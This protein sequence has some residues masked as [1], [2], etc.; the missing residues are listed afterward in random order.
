MKKRKELD[1]LIG[2]GG[3]SKRK[4]TKKGSGHRLLR[5]EPPD[6][7]SVSSSDEDE[8][9]TL[10]SSGFKG[11]YTQC[12]KVCY[13]LCAF[14]VLVACVVACCGL[15]WMQVALKEDLDAMKEKIRTMES[16]Q[17]ISSHEI[18]KL[19]EDLLEKQKLLEN[20]ESGSKGLNK[21]WTNMTE[22]NKQITLLDSTVSHLKANIK[23]ASDL[24]NLPTTV[25]ELQKSVASIGS[26][27]T[28]VQHDVE[29]MQ[30]SLDKKIVD[31]IKKNEDEKQHRQSASSA[32]P[33]SNNCTSCVIFKQDVLRLH[34]AI[35]ELNASHVIYQTQN[36]QKI[37]DINSTVHN[38]TQRIFSL[39]ND[40]FIS[41]F[42]R[43]PKH[44]DSETDDHQVAELRE[45]LL[46]INALTSKTDSE[47][48]IEDSVHGDPQSEHPFQK[49][50]KKTESKE[51][52]IISVHSQKP[53]SEDFPKNLDNEKL[54]RDA[55]KNSGN[56]EITRSKDLP[57]NSDSAKLE[58]E[59]SPKNSDNSKDLPGTN[60]KR[61][62]NMKSEN[63]PK[64]LDHSKQESGDL[65]ENS[66][67][68]TGG[69][70]LYSTSKPTR[71]PRYISRAASRESLKDLED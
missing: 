5:T 56:G 43:P 9:N 16:N 28:S 44:N 61:P 23:S 42:S 57:A 34:D 35:N 29:T 1:A 25:E 30:T 45:K 7:D 24:I 67:N 48:L 52:P 58:N 32:V 46:L 17:K 65:P 8:F 33:A 22:I 19:N 36:D 59:D 31:S 69:H 70:P 13:P 55:V 66:D 41:S 15:I 10:G 4:K 60:N 49:N 12:C 14:I 62:K 26:T 40:V 51:I 38:I 39:E 54:E 37:S 6:S 68:V 53:N 3:D 50:G 64:N 11:G 20:M 71:F 2:L 27:L 21:M 18:S 47:Q 63:L